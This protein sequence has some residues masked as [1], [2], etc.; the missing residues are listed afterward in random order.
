MSDLSDSAQ[1][2]PNDET[3]TFTVHGIRVSVASPWPEF[4]TLSDLMF[5][6]FDRSG[7]SSESLSVHVDL[8]VRGWF[9]SPG[10]G[11]ER[12]GKEE[13]LGTNEFLEGGTARYAAGKLVVR[14]TDGNDALVRASYILDRTSRVRRIFGKGQPWEDEFALFRLGVQEP[15]LLKLE[16]RGA[17]ILHASAVARDGR[18]V[19]LVGL[20]GSGKS[21]LCAS[22]L[23]QLD[24]VSDNFVALDRSSVLGFPAALRMP[25]PPAAGS[26]A[27]PT[28]HGKY[29]M[30][31][32][33][34]KTK[35]TAEA[36]ALVFLSLGNETAFARLPPEEGFRRLVQ[37][38]EMTHE[39]PRHTYL[40]PL[41]PPSSLEGLEVLARAVPS[42]RLVMSRTAEAR[43]RVLSLF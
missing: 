34:G 33:S 39:F 18:A 32:D 30:R 8:R 23:D 40:G 38:Q 3:R 6:A 15:V 2:R 7:P 24:Y 26:P 29:F 31:P 4:L 5:G 17:L 14:Y 9:E 22:L 35:T 13:R 11:I 10:V 42:Y 12:R 37:V 21:T 1:P 43:E 25:G 36:L 28:A 19:L 27:L 16:R 41:A 20:N